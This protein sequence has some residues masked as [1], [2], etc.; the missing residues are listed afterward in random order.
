M[1]GFKYGYAMNDV[2]GDKR[3]I[4]P[5]MLGEK[6]SLSLGHTSTFVF[7]GTKA[8]ILEWFRTVGP[9]KVV[10]AVLFYDRPADDPLAP[11]IGLVFDLL[12]YPNPD[13]TWTQWYQSFYR[14]DPTLEIY[15]L[16]I[17]PEQPKY[18][19]EID[20]LYRMYAKNGVNLGDMAHALEK[21]WSQPPHKSYVDMV[22][23]VFMER[24]DADEHAEEVAKETKRLDEEGR[25]VDLEDIVVSVPN[26]TTRK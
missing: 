2:P 9:T 18:D 5:P 20:P 14:S 17:R 24:E 3:I 22:K 8:E 26:E 7:I 4:T 6:I 12:P 15:R 10:Q 16:E 19:A 23:E 1:T 25:E 21:K 13:L 11:K